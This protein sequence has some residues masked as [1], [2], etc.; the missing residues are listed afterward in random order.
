MTK[1]RKLTQGELLALGKERFG[2]D[3]MKYAFACPNCDDVASLG[4]FAAAGADPGKAGQEC[5][6]RS[7]GAL[8]NPPTNTRGCNW[9]AYGLIP[10]PWEI[11]MPAEG[12]RPERSARSFPLAE[13]ASA[14]EQRDAEP[15]YPA[16]GSTI[17][18]Q[19]G[20]VVGTCGHRVAR[21]EWRAGFRRCERCP[22]DA[23][24]DDEDPGL[25]E[26]R[27]AIAA[28]EERGDSDTANDLRDELRQRQDG[29]GPA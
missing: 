16:V 22:A 5:I 27:S 12:D 19:P 15:V 1:H 13:G 25:G 28:A 8:N 6:G 4:D 18:D 7:I 14:N 26:I 29:G 11:V 24:P 2:D 10:G 21:Q 23:T 17:P 3:P 9:V 20:F